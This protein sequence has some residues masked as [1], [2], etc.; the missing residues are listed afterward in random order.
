MCSYEIS[1]KF[2][3]VS[4]E[5]PLTTRGKRVYSVHSKSWSSP[6]REGDQAHSELARDEGV[7]MY[8]PAVDQPDG[9]LAGKRAEKR[10]KR[11]KMAVMTNQSH[12]FIFIG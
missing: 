2:Q 9:V 10:S 6:A 8:T 12:I 7:I 11:Q 4:Y 1:T 5:V 3:A